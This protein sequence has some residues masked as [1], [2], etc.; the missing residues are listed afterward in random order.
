MNMTGIHTPGKHAIVLGGGMAGLLAARVLADH[1]EEV[2]LIERDCYPEEPIFRPGIPQG[3]HVHILLMRGQLILEELFPGIKQD[4]LARGAIDSD[5]TNDYLFHVPTGWLPRSPSQFQ[6]YVCSRPLLEWQVH[7]ALLKQPNVHI[8]EEHEVVNL[9]ANADATSI[10]GVSLRRRTHTA[11]VDNDTTQLTGD[12][13]VDAT[14]RDTKASHWL[15][16]LGYTPPPETIINPFF[17][18]ASRVYAPSSDA[19]RNWKGMVI[20]ANPPKQLRSGVIWPIEGGHWMVVLGGTG[21]DYPPT[22]EDEFLA[23]ARSLPERAFADALEAAQPLSPI[24]GYRRTENRI[25]HFERL[26]RQPEGFIALGDAACSFNPVYGQGMTVAALGALT[27]RECLR[28]CEKDG[29]AK[30]P[31]RFQRELARTNTLPWALATSTDVRAPGV[32]GAI[33]R[34]W[35]TRLQYGY[36]DRL[37]KILPTNPV[38]SRAF[39]GVLHLVKPP[40]ALFHP[41]IVMNILLREVFK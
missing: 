40:S 33:T 7:Q 20:Q 35:L 25:R 8:I 11:P 31:R 21:K 19:H 41:A 37:I 26:Q 16:A 38:A 36:F 32:E 15:K 18:Y 2:S 10:T 4:L 13:V 23:F 30:L 27:L 12:L 17:G 9:L 29:L 22:N 34:N 6:G 24:Y 39:T 1:F 3:R 5:F 28:Q 14:G